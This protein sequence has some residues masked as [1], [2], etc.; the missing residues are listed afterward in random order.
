[1]SND[2]ASV[3]D[4]GTRAYIDAVGSDPRK[5][6]VALV[7]AVSASTRVEEKRAQQRREWSALLATV[8]HRAARGG[9]IPSGDLEVRVSA[10]MGAVNYVVYDWSVSEPRL[11]L[12]DVVRVL[13]RMLVGAITA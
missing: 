10:L 7:E 11:P 6:R 5:A 13:R 4:A 8:A 3:V 2:A 9:G 12:D 1:M